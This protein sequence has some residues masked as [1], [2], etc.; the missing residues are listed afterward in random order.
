MLF[1][2]NICDTTKGAPEVIEFLVANNKKGYL[3]D[4]YKS[5][6]NPFINFI[7]VLA[8][9]LSRTTEDDVKRIFTALISAG[10]DPNKLATVE[11]IHS[12]EFFKDGKSI[13]KNQAISIGDFCL[14][15]GDDNQLFSM[16]K[17]KASITVAGL[18]SKPTAGMTIKEIRQAPSKDWY[19]LVT[20][21][22]MSD[23]LISPKEE[24]VT[25]KNSPVPP[26]PY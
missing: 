13:A 7:T 24:P 3:T 5:K 21:F 11:Q 23:E 6:D 9:R 22:S 10:F 4:A 16:A 8:I 17:L 1:Y 25:Q 26:M 15:M 19:S 2:F 18:S 14:T 12:A 20:D